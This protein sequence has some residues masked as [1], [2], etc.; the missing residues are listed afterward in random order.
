MAIFMTETIHEGS[1]LY[2]AYMRGVNPP[3]IARMQVIL[4]M[5]MVRKL[6]YLSLFTTASIL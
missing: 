1:S 4:S 3:A 2:T 6:V 5:V